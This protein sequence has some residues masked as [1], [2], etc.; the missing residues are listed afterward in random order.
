MDAAGD[1]GGDNDLVAFPPGLVPIGLSEMVHK[2]WRDC[3]S[4]GLVPV[5]EMRLAAVSTCGATR[6]DAPRSSTQSKVSGILFGT[7]TIGA[8]THLGKRGGSRWLP[9]SDLPR[10]GQDDI[11]PLRKLAARFF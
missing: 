1:R 9:P 5:G 7:R 8:T 11:R 3:G 6:A 2:P 10:L 4:Q